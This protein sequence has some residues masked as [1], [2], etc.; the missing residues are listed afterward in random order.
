MVAN[1]LVSIDGQLPALHWRRLRGRRQ[2]HNLADEIQDT[3]R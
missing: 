1:I 3:T 2:V